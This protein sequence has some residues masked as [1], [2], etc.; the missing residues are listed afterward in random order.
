MEHRLR[1]VMSRESDLG[2]KAGL[3]DLLKI[4]GCSQQ[5]LGDAHMRPFQEGEAL[6]RIRESA[7]SG[8]ESS[9]WFIALSSAVVSVLSALAAWLAV[10]KNPNQ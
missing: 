6:R 5:D 7:R 3:D 1:D 4:F 9:L 10:L 2:R 8:R